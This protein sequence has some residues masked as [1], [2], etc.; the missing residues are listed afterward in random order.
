MNKKEFFW[1]KK[2]EYYQFPLWARIVAGVCSAAWTAVK[3]ALGTAL[4]AVAIMLVAGSVFAVYLGDYL[5]KDV[6]PDSDY[7]YENF[8]LDQTSFIHYIDGDKIVDSQKIYTIIDRVWVEYDQIPEDLIHAAVAIEDKR[9]F[10]HQGVD[11]FTTGKACVNM[12]LGSRSTFGGSTITQQLIKNTSGDDDV[13]VRRKVQEIFRALSFEEKYDKK[14]VMKWYLNTIYLGENCYGVQTAARMYFGKDVKDLTAA[15]CASLIGITNNPSLYDPYIS[16]E[17]NRKRQLIILEEMRNQEYLTQEEYEE[18]VNQK[19]I[20]TSV[21]LSDE[22][23]TCPS[24]E[25]IGSRDTYDYNRT[26]KV[27]SCPQCGGAVEIPPEEKEDYYTYYEDTIIR[28]VCDDL[29]EK[30]GYTYE[31]AMKLLK[32]G[33]FHIY[34]CEDTHVQEIVD[35]VYQNLENI[36]TTKSMQQ[37]QSAIIVIDNATGD[38]VAMAGGVGVKETYL[39]L[40]RA[41]GSHLQ[42]GSAIKPV[43]V[44]GPALELGI[45]DPAT[46]IFDGPLDVENQYPQNY[47][48]VY[49]GYTIVQDG[50]SQSMNTVACK[51]VDAMGVDYSFDF[52]KNKFGLSDLVESETINGS[53]KTD[54]A[55]APLAMGA[56]TYGVTVRDLTTA[57]ATFTNNGVWRKSRTY[58]K[59]LDSDGQLV[60]D[61]TQETRKILS[62]KSVNYMNSMLQYAVQNGTSYYARIP[63]MTVAGKTGTTSGD[64]DRWFAGYTPYYTAVVWFGFDQPETI[65]LTGSYVNPAARLWKQVMEPLHENLE[66]AD[67][68]DYDSMYTVSICTESGLLATDACRADARDSSCVMSVRLYREDIPSKYCN[69]HVMASYCEGGHAMAGP[70]CS[71]VP[72]NKVIQKGLVKMTDEMRKNYRGAGIDISSFVYDEKA[73]T[74]PV[75]VKGSIF[76]PGKPTKPTEKPDDENKPPV[77]P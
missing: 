9:F 13:T 45:I 1:E 54:V 34:A 49:S 41:T 25:F 16:M 7:S 43:S 32:T 69:V 67:L 28:D 36:P 27:Y 19:M 62:E 17:R 35:Q 21:S 6:I 50:V 59:V 74:C 65:R 71:L 60:L 73:K 33:G 48:R 38:I 29:M 51:V 24:C 11:W 4:V 68:I 76:D 5:Q 8:D 55:I 39:G 26:S 40:N 14:E 20:F 44:Y 77:T 22:L 47:D 12:F 66:D 31:V 10:Q 46:L 57:Y 52:A 2:K 3:V 30:Y 72:G 23:Y 61:N 37:P 56:P 58:L 15:E 64:R 42:P 70:L 18:A 75:H 63:G 53:E